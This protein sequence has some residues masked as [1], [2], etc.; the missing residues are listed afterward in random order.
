[1][2]INFYNNPFKTGGEKNSRNFWDSRQFLEQNPGFA[3]RKSG[4]QRIF[5]KNRQLR[6]AV[7]FFFAE[8]ISINFGFLESTISESFIFV[9]A[10]GRLSEIPRVTEFQ[11]VHLPDSE[12]HSGNFKT[13]A[14]LAIRLPPGFFIMMFLMR[15]KRGPSR[16]FDGKVLASWVNQHPRKPNFGNSK[17]R[18]G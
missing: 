10:E 15:K 4:I 16:F 7:T 14:D 1:M 11:A 18:L 12:N 13:A 2:H 6:R 8:P 5:S 17:R 9:P 3:V